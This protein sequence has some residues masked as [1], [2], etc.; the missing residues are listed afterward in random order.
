MINYTDNFDRA[1]W[2]LS[3][4]D[5]F[6]QEV[7]PGRAYQPLFFGDLEYADAFHKIVGDFLANLGHLAIEA[8][9][10]REHLETEFELAMETFQ[11]EHDAEREDAER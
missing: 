4:L 2:A 1:S 9:F 3:A 5:T 10:T 6:V 11:K 8:G 7:Q